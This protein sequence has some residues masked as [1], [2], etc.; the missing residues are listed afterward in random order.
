MLALTFHGKRRSV[1]ERLLCEAMTFLVLANWP[2]PL[3]DLTPSI[4]GNDRRCRHTQQQI[5][6]S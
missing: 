3:M 5:L 4:K 1:S 2:A 6:F